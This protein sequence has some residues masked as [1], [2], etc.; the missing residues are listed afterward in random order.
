MRKRG[1]TVGA[2]GVRIFFSAGRSGPLNAF[3]TEQRALLSEIGCDARAE[4][5]VAG[6]QCGD[7]G[8]DDANADFPRAPVP[9]VD[10]L[11]G[12]VGVDVLPVEDGAD[13]GACGG[14]RMKED[15]AYEYIRERER[16]VGDV[17][18]GEGGFIIT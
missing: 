9:V 17:W 18:G 4:D 2:S 13:D 7:A 14:A 1:L 8:G 16:V 10:A 15:I 11:P 5:A 6:P 3:E 12:G